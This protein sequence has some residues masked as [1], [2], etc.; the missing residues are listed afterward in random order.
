MNELE[1]FEEGI[2]LIVDDNPTNLG[3][4]F[5]CFND[6]GF[7]VLVA[8]DGESAI[9]KVE[10]AHPDIILLDVLMPGIDGFE[11]CRRLKAKAATQEIP[12][13]FMTALTEMVDKV[14]GFQ[15]GAVDYITKPVQHEEVLARVKTHITIRKLTKQLQ[16]KNIHLQQEISNKE[17]AEAEARNALLKEKEL[18]ELKSRF[19]SMASHEIRTPLA[20]ISFSA[21]FLQDYGNRCTEEKKQTHLQRIQH[22]VHRMTQMLDEVLLI[23][24]AEAGKLELQRAPIE[25][26]SLCRELVAE[27]QLS[28][29]PNHTLSFASRGQCSPAH[30]D[31]KLLRHIL[32]NLLSNAIKYSPK[33]GTIFCELSLENGEAI[34]RVKDQGIG[35]PQEDIP[36]LFETFHRANNVG[37]IPGTGLGLAIIK[38]Y[39]DMHS[40]EI[41]V[42]S[43]VGIGTT[44]TV[45]I[46][47][48]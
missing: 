33:G 44:F 37:T 3:V 25:L 24:K 30:L 28:A 5:D 16:E 7:E 8:Q 39:V 35:I 40:G 46:P 10:Y 19:V 32:T 15:L 42:D 18:G 26:P 11:T 29:S 38:K 12:V 36:R 23:G 20:T 21:G 27:M 17:R 22:A 43:Q 4:L 45:K 41:I 48:Q 14:R 1:I 6:F 13:I 31:E 34:F 2:I 47:L 9:E